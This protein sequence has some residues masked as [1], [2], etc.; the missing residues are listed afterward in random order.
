MFFLINL[1][2]QMLIF[3]CYESKFDVID[4]SI[5]EKK[6]VFFDNKSNFYVFNYVQK[7]L[8][9][10]PSSLAIKALPIQKNFNYYLYQNKEEIMQINSEFKNYKNEK[11][12]LNYDSG[13]IDTSKIDKNNFYFVIHYPNKLEATFTV[14][15]S[16]TGFDDVSFQD[17]SFKNIE[18]YIFKFNTPENHKKYVRVGSIAWVNNPTS[19]LTV[20]D[21]NKEIIYQKEESTYFEDYI[22]VGYSG[23]YYF[24]FTFNCQNEQFT[25]KSFVY[26][27]QADDY[28]IVPLEMNENYRIP[29]IKEFDVLLDISSIKT[30]ENVI[31]QYNKEWYDSQESFN[32]FGYETNNLDIIRNSTG[33]YLTIFDKKCN[34]DICK[35]SI[36]KTFSKLAAIKLTIPTDNKKLKF[37]KFKYE[38]DF[39]SVFPNINHPYYSILLGVLFSVPNIVWFITRRCKKKMSATFGTF[40]MNIL[41]NMT[42]GTLVG[43]LFG[44]GNKT[45]LVIAESLG[46]IYGSFCLLSLLFQCC[47]IRGYFDVIYNLCKTLDDSASFQTT[48]K[49]NRRLY[50]LILVGCYADHQESREVWTEYEEYDKEVYKTE[51]ISDGEGGYTTREVFSHYE[52]DYRY[53]TTHYAEWERVDNGGGKIDGIPGYENSKYEK[54]VEHRTVETWRREVEYIY[55]SWQDE[56]TDLKDIPY[57]TIIEAAFTYEINLDSASENRIQEIKDDLYKEGRTYDTDVHTYDKRQVPNLIEKIKCTLN[58]EEYQRIKGKFSNCCGYFC[59]TVLF[60]LGY[61]SIFESFARYDIGEGKIN[62]IKSI[63]SQLDKRASYKAF[64]DDAPPISIIYSFTKF[65]N[66]QI[67]RKMEKNKLNKKDLNL[68]LITVY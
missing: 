5:N 38:K 1:S 65:Q 9:N 34:N 15:S 48:I 58:D 21:H 49:A 60:I 23:T 8:N 6:T 30:D 53:L 52:K 7:P 62:I 36:L 51:R 12:L 67:Q 26:L 56:T 3:Y 13:I 24:N 50:P 33:Q 61:S 16:E 28:G 25:C 14:L 40:F 42:Y 44:L 66:K 2:I 4:I 39:S 31:F 64:D 27:M 37:I 35:C 29:V 20:I 17:Y 45:S 22:N 55:Q 32:A 59:W 47:G 68:P 63:S 43:G 18:S 11:T 57:Y 46:I 54:T 41:L 19:I 10:F